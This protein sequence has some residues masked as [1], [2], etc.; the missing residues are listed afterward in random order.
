M[1]GYQI[2]LDSYNNFIQDQ[3][4]ICNNF[5]NLD[6]D[7]FFGIVPGISD[8]IP[9]PCWRGQARFD[10]R[11]RVIGDSTS[12]T[13]CYENRGGSGGQFVR[14]CYTNFILNTD[15]SLYTRYSQR[16][17]PDNYNIFDSISS[18]IACSYSDSLKQGYYQLRRRNTCQGYRPPRFI[19]IYGDP[20]YITLDNFEYTF[21]GFG[22]YLLVRTMPSVFPSFEL[23]GR[24][25]TSLNV[26]QATVLTGLAFQ[27]NNLIRM[28]IL[29]EPSAPLQMNVTF[30]ISG[31]MPINL[32]PML[33]QQGDSYSNA[34]LDIE[35]DSSNNFLIILGGSLSLIVSVKNGILDYLLAL[36]PEHKYNTE[37]LM[38]TWNDNQEDDLI[39]YNSFIPISINSS[40]RAIHYEFGQTWN[41]SMTTPLFFYPSGQDSSSY[42]NNA[43]E[44][45]FSDEI[46]YS[47]EAIALCDTSPPC[48][49]DFQQTG[50]EMIATN[51][52]DQNTD[53]FVQQMGISNSP[54]FLFL[55]NGSSEIR[56]IRG[57]QPHYFSVQLTDEDTGAILQVNSNHSVFLPMVPGLVLSKQFTISLSLPQPA[58]TP[59][60]LSLIG[61]DVQ[62]AN[63]SINFDI[64]ACA[65]ENGGMCRQGVYSF[66]SVSLRYKLEACQC[67]AGYTGD[68]CEMDSDGCLQQECYPGV[69]CTD[70][71]P[72]SISGQCGPCPTGTSGNG[73]ICTDLNECVNESG[74][75]HTCMSPSQT[76]VNVV[77]SFRCD[78]TQGYIQQA[79]G[80]CVDINECALNPCQ[81]ICENTVGGFVCKC[82]D[83]FQLNVTTGMC[84]T[85]QT[86]NLNCSNGVCGVVNG[87]EVCFC[88][89][90]YEEG[91]VA[92]SCVDINEC[93]DPPL[94]SCEH[95]CTNVEKTYTCSCRS[96]YVL[97]TDS[98]SC[99]DFNECDDIF[100]V[101]CPATEICV[102]T[103]GSY[104]CVAPTTPTQ[105]TTSVPTTPSGASVSVS[106][107]PLFIAVVLLQALFALL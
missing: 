58:S 20:H 102:N 105:S 93:A 48:L 91:S 7:L 62:G 66:E 94:H 98:L 43:F 106:L 72:P 2:S 33:L 65:C 50:N 31:G 21:N 90:G 8:S 97:R 4:Q 88:D 3:L 87:S 16:L 12:G 99:G 42:T 69:T 96:G 51:S 30:S 34:P 100:T 52:A 53:F 77:G 38:G 24:T 5:I 63:A 45:L 104:S 18:A 80:T 15:L 46:T 13:V 14:C 76:C 41:L 49:F 71:P 82:H 32:T 1:L 28:E 92:D 67:T 61:I 22:E 9:C 17:D 11:F 39:P 107:F 84:F 70:L 44:P 103:V 36:P 79:S 29:L 10:R 73:M 81:Q 89:D 101:A 57:E 47:P 59:F 6:L 19:C 85:N 26:T 68:L 40:Q 64:I 23:Q 27:F 56:L 86:C 75:F 35:V 78:C 95:N 60:F 37:G 25:R 55:L 54:P 74:L 83:G